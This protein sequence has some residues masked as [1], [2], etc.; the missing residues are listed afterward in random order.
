MITKKTFR[1]SAVLGKRINNKKVSK[2]VGE[3]VG[4]RVGE[5]LG[6]KLGENEI[7]I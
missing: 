5:K 1:H 6:V 2:K 7:K 4:K 3:K